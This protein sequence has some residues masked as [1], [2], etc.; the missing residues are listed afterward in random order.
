[1]NKKKGPPRIRLLKDMPGVREPR[2]IQRG[3]KCCMEGTVLTAET[4]KANKNRFC[5]TTD[6][7]IQFRKK[8]GCAKKDFWENLLTMLKSKQV[9]RVI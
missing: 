5:K 2:I 1:M 3:R 6:T 9:R 7:R 4:K 8:N